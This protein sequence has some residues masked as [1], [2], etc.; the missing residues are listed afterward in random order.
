ML[1]GGQGQHAS[2]QQVMDISRAPAAAAAAA[3]AGELPA[4]SICSTQQAV[5]QM[6]RPA[7]LPPG[8]KGASAG[9]VGGCPSPGGCCAAAGASAGCPA[10][11]PRTHHPRA[12]ADLEGLVAAAAAHRH[13][14]LGA[15]LDHGRHL[16]AQTLLALRGSHL[17]R[18]PAARQ[19]EA[20]GWACQA[21]LRFGW[22]PA[23]PGE[24]Q[25][26]R[27]WRCGACPWPAAGTIG[28]SREHMMASRWPA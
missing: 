28:F 7:K 18:A 22:L 13:G 15:G 1:E 14:R 16:R 21:A 11:A 20:G 12:D 6:Q 24:G 8:P 10:A 23:S 2:C 26:G 17:K 3:A 4:S 9:E 27:T 25:P 19:E 5:P